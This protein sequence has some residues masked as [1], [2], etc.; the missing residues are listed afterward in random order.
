VVQQAVEHGADG[1]HIAQQ[2]SPVFDRTIRSQQRAGAFVAPHDDSSRSSAAVKGSLRMPKSSMMSSGT[3]ASDSMNSLRVPSATAS[4]RSLEQ[5]VRFAVDHAIA[6]LNG[7]LADGL[8]QVT[9]ARAARADRE[10]AR[11]HA[12]R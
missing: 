6:L 10:T 2:F 3:V 11:L 5:G 7:R 8:G 4:A 12:C 1:G 9:L